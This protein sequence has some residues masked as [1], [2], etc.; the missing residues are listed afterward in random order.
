LSAILINFD[1]MNLK[2]E[3]LRIIDEYDDKS[4]VFI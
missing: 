2:P 4:F 1:N 3:L